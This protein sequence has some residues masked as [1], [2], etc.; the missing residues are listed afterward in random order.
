MHSVALPTP[1][2]YVALDSA[3]YDVFLTNAC[4]GVCALWDIRADRCAAR[5][6]WRGA[7]KKGEGVA[8][9]RWFVTQFSANSRTGESI[10]LLNSENK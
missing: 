1:S 5:F 6:R 2:S 4:D 8:W 7:K 9:G 3:H 10:F